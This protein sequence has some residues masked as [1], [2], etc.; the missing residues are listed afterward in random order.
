MYYHVCVNNI[1]L[2]DVLRLQKI[3]TM[4]GVNLKLCMLLIRPCVMHVIGLCKIIY[5]VNGFVH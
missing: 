3:V 1:P 2:N 5:T 4:T